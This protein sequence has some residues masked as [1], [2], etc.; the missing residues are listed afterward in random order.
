MGSDSFS[1]QGLYWS[2]ARNIMYL[3]EVTSKGALPSLLFFSV[4]VYPSKAFDPKKAEQFTKDYFG[5]ARV[6]SKEF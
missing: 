4:G 5:A 1:S 3:G 2:V 6:V